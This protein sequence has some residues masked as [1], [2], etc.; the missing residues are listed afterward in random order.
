MKVSKTPIFTIQWGPPS[1]KDELAII[2]EEFAKLAPKA[3]S[4]SAMYKITQNEAFREYLARVTD[5]YAGDAIQDWLRGEEIARKQIPIPD[6][7]S[8]RF[9][10]QNVESFRSYLEAIL[11]IW[12]NPQALY[13]S[14]HGNGERF[15]Y[16]SNESSTLSFDCLTDI[17]R[18]AFSRDP[19]NAVT[20]VLGCCYG[21]D[22][23]SN[24]LSLL[25]DQIVEVYGFTH[26]PMSTDVAKLFVS[27]LLNDEE[28]FYQ[29]SSANKGIY[30][31]GVRGDGI[32]DALVQ[33]RNDFEQITD[34]FKESPT[35]LIDGET[36]VAVRMMKRVRYDDN[37][38]SW[39]GRSIPL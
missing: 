4:P 37:G 8:F 3:L 39:Q 34:N 30:G 35:R 24:L 22:E 25:P 19:D 13:F 20:L 9:T 15:S 17:F 6:I 26:K 38:F 2:E 23:R 29:Y 21:L 32:L 16:D 5:G 27:I 14:C 7:S 11:T 18:N 36:G 10:D 31:S 1:E 28:L 12:Q 33:I